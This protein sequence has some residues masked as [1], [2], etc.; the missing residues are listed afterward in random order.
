MV[1]EVGWDNEDTYEK[2]SSGGRVDRYRAEQG[3]RDRVRILSRSPYAYGMHWTG[4]KYVNCGLDENGNGTCIPCG[5]KDD[6]GNPLYPIQEKYGCLVMLVKCKSGKDWKEKQ[7]VMF[8]GFG[9]DKY[10][11]LFELREDYGDLT[12]MDL[13]ISCDDTQMQKLRIG[14]ASGKS[15]I[16]VDELKGQIENA[17]KWLKIYLTPA[18]VEQQKK[19]LGYEDGDVEREVS[20]RLEVDDEDDGEPERDAS[21]MSDLKPADPVKDEVESIVDEIGEII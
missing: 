9:G 16:D 20:K 5:E 10:R 4:S 14:P 17:K 1:K 7:K 19:V 12:Q 6:D 8:W 15:E 21:D 2:T 11:A 3:R 13:M 18:T